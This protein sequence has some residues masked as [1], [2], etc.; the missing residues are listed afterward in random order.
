ME[1]EQV[2]R[3]A[4]GWKRGNIAKALPVDLDTPFRMVIHW[5]ML[6]KVDSRIRLGPLSTILCRPFF[7]ARFSFRQVFSSA[8]KNARHARNLAILGIIS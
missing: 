4:A 7:L 3:L 2:G 1:I 8:L 6:P 5:P